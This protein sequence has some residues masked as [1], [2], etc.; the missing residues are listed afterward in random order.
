MKLRRSWQEKEKRNK[1]LVSSLAVGEVV[2]VVKMMDLVVDLVMMDLG[3]VL[4]MMDPDLEVD[5]PGSQVLEDGE[6]ENRR[7]R[8][9]GVLEVEEEETEGLQ[10]VDLLLH[11]TGIEEMQVLGDV[12]V[13][14]EMTDL[15]QDEMRD[16]H[17]EEMTGEEVVTS[18]LVVEV[19]TLVGIE[20]VEM[21]EETLEET[22]IVEMMDLGD[23]EEEVV[24]ETL[25]VTDAEEV[26][27][28]LGIGEEVEDLPIVDLEMTIVE[29]LEMTTDVV[30]EMMID[31]DLEM[32]IV[33]LLVMMVQWIGAVDLEDLPVMMTTAVDPVMMTVVDPKMKNAVDPLVIDQPEI[34]MTAG[35]RSTSVRTSQISRVLC[36]R[37]FS[38]RVHLSNGA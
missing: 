13:V 17:Q 15:L 34:K 29:D 4:E 32:M 35:R 8:K 7:S 30:Q 33:V 2:E 24:R 16:L 14:A 19:V 23:V 37:A 1:R 26:I 28:T 21:E 20:I 10:D 3:V 27:E 38:A 22:E 9:N 5:L 31:V 11:E 36:A 6:I 18:A 25:V 12:E